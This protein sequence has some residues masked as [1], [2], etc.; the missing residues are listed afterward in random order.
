MR[1]D[2]VVV[3]LAEVAQPVDAVEP[4]G[5][6]QPAR[7]RLDVQMAWWSM[8]GLGDGDREWSL[9]EKFERIAAA[10]FTGIFGGVPAAAEREQWS[11][12]MDEYGF[13]FATGG[14]P[15]SAADLAV[16][17]EEAREFG[18]SYVNSQVLD[19]FVTGE[20]AIR[21]LGELDAEAEK[22][23][24]PHY[25]ETHR[26]RITQ[27]LLRTVDYVREL[28]QLKLTI[29]FS[30]YIVAGE[31]DGFVKDYEQEA[32]TYFDVLL[33]RASCIHGRVSNGQQVQVG[34]A[35]E[36]QLDRFSVWWAKG[37]AYWLE[38]AA[39]GASFPFVCELGPAPYE[40]AG[41]SAERFAESVR[42]KERAEAIWASVA[43]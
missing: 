26:G 35:D 41:R 33:Q 14:F 39:P 43:R 38:S 31:M 12:L 16:T 32:E 13:S 1:K 11:R 10:G 27:D 21:L 28:P 36:D 19:S 18:A 6:N 23:G 5:H 34:L 3:G 7:R 42:L 29:D 2:E 4:A 8:T 30:H 17:L 25:V 40:L 37:M 9:E 24:I 20:D 15:R 22:F